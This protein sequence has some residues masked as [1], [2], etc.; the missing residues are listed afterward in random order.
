MQSSQKKIMFILASLG[1]VVLTFISGYFLGSSRGIYNSL[2]SSDGQVE[3]TK[4]LD[5]YGKSRSSSVNFDQFW[6][7][8]DM[9]KLGHV[10]QPVDEV[11]LFYGA[12]EGLVAGLGDPYSVYFPPKQA[13]EFAN[14]LSGE[15]EG[16]GAELGKKDDVLTIIAPLPGSPAEKAGIKIGDKIYAINKEDALSLTVE[17]AIQKIRGPHGTEV[18][19]TVTQKGPESLREIKIIR[20]KI[21]V[22]TVVWEKKEKSIAYLRINYFNQET[23]PQFR[24]VI[25]EI[26]SF[27]AKGIVLDM[28]G[29]PG[30][31]LDTSVAVA[32]EWIK[33]GLIVRE[34]FHDKTIK[35]YVSMGSSHEF[36]TMPTVVLVDEGTASGAEI[37][38]GAL[39]DYG[40]AQLIGK[41]T[42]GKGSVQNFEPLPDGSAVKLTVAK[43]FT[44]KER[45]IDKEGIQ[46]DI[47]LEE[48]FQEDK[49]QPK[50]FRDLG[51]EKAIEILTK[52]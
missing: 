27:G 18:V 24:K 1:I 32:S 30:G 29:N 36:A 39:Q 52:N 35:D 22:P 37:V 13:Q 7:V 40:L 21:V 50:G 9:V 28:R 26:K 44:P 19:L 23:L 43:W 31:Y 3:I 8:W 46:P 12:L 38:A 34:K 41:K 2:V 17:E 10:E 51:L 16:I 6:K 49:K 42:F 14:D 45:A 25:N 20:D 5:L 48:M 47:V 33:E 15:F 11:K 4:V